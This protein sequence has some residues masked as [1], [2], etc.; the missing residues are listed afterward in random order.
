MEPISSLNKL[1]PYS[2]PLPPSCVGPTASGMKERSPSQT[3]VKVCPLTLL[4]EK[5]TQ[6]KS[7]TSSVCIQCLTEDLKDTTS[8]ITLRNCSKDVKGDV[9]IYMILVKIISADSCC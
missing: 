2:N 1:N 9:S 6:H 4:T 3:L 8:Q 7:C 5:E